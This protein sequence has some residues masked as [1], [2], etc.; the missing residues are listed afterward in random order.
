MSKQ[1]ELAKEIQVIRCFLIARCNG[2]KVEA[3]RQ[4]LD[5]YAELSFRHKTI[6]AEKNTEK[7]QIAP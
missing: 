5:M 7:L 4:M 2:E 3:F 6:E 1:D